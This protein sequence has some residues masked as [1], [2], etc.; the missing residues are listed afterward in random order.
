VINA[1]A[2]VINAERAQTKIGYIF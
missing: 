2:H 1:Q